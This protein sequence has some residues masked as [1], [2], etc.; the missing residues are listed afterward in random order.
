[1]FALGCTGL[2]AL[3]IINAQAYIYADMG[4]AIGDG[5][6]PAMFYGAHRH[7]RG[8]H[9]HRHPVLRRRRLPLLGGR[10]QDN[11]IVAA[12]A[13][14]WYTMSAV[15]YGDLVRRLRHQVSH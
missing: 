9:D 11:E 4:L 6:Y 2:I 13:M 10:S 7:V 15:F 3:L 12:H 1:M 8:P 14:Y 5:I